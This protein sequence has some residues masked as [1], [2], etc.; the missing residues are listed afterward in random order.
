MDKAISLGGFLFSVCGAAVVAWGIWRA[1]TRPHSESENA[2]VVNL[3]E[4]RSSE[5][6]SLTGEIAGMF[7]R[8]D[9]PDDMS[10]AGVRSVDMESGVERVRHPLSE[11]VSV[12]AEPNTDDTEPVSGATRASENDTY[13][14]DITRAIVIAELLDSGLLTNRDKAIMQV[15]RCSKASSSR[16]EAPFQVAL[17][18]VERHRDKQR[19]EYIGEMIERVQ[20]EVAQE[21]S[22]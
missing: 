12:S 22:R 17:K 11:P 19:P 10:S 18:L 15:F 21:T 16:P 9:V 4:R 8:R 6:W 5:R 1:W 14:R 3:A 2:P 13:A 7:L 20:R